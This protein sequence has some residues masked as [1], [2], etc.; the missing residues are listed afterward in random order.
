M[1]KLDQ[2]LQIVKQANATDLHLS[3]GSVPLIRV[4]GCLEKTKHKKLTSDNVRQLVYEILTDDQIRQFE[5][6]GDIDIAYGLPGIARFRINMYQMFSGIGAAIRLIPDQLLDLVS[7]G[8]SEHVARLAE[9]RSGLVLVT[10][11]TN[12][13]KTTTLAAMVDHINTSYSRHVITL[14]DPIEYVHIC[15]NSLISQRQ[16]GLHAKSFAQGLRAALREDPDVILV[17]ELRDTETISLAITAAEAGL[18]VLGTLHTCTAAASI[19][20]IIDVFP[21]DQQQQVRVMLADALFGVVSQQLV[22][23]ADGSGRV[24]AYELLTR[25]TAVANLIREA[26]T[27]QI[28]TVIQSNRRLGMRLLDHHLK[29]LV[30]SGVVATE[31]AVRAACD[32]SQFID[33]MT[34]IEAEAVTT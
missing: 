6:T 27:H 14:E 11:P 18:L 7:L 13:G 19:D 34:S 4:G 12:C 28:P 9:S 10:G 32:P 33:R 31:E 23:R 1:P 21:P 8:F 16:I 3:A 30:D 26:K 22:K 17:G 24:V 2:L 5:K 20:R 25:T 15:K 29:A